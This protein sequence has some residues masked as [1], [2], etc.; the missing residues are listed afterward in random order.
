MLSCLW[1]RTENKNEP[2]L[3]DRL[4]L[5]I[6]GQNYAF[7]RARVRVVMSQTSEGP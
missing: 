3:A 2:V 6:R 7:S 1:R 4:K 5:Y